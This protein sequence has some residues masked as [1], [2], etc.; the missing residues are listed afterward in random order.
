ME[1]M[2]KP[3]AREWPPEM[4]PHETILE[5]GDEALGSNHRIQEWDSKAVQD[6]TT[7]KGHHQDKKK[8]N[9]EPL[10]GLTEETIASKAPDKQVDKQWNEC[11]KEG[12]WKNAKITVIGENMWKII[13]NPQHKL[14][15]TKRNVLKI[16]KAPKENHRRATALEHPERHSRKEIGW[17]DAHHSQLTWQLAALR[18]NVQTLPHIIIVKDPTRGRNSIAMD[19]GHVKAIVLLPYEAIIKA[20][21][22]AAFTG[23]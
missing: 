1:V 10:E 6:T 12:W 9:T 21:E 15:V 13:M 17:N 20:P 16:V 4:S 19:H 5:M 18:T 8:N 11:L 23:E 3:H 22:I 2:I 7:V 14:S